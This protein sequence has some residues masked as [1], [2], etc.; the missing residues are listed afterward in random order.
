MTESFAQLF[1]ESLKEIETRPGSIVRGVVVAIDKDVVLVDAGLKSESAIPAEQFKNAQG[2]LEIQVGDEVDVALDAVEDGFGETLLSREKA[3]RHEAWITLEKAYEEA[4]TVVGVINGKVK[5]G[6]TVEL[7]GIRAF[8]PGSLVDVRPVRDTLH[9][10][11]K[12]LEFKVIKLDQKR[13]NVVVSRRAVIESENSAERDQLL[14][15]LQEGM[16]VKGIVKNLTDYG[17]FVDLG[18][19]DGLLHITDMAWKRV[20]HPSEI[21]NVGDE[22]TV[23]VLK[24]DRERTRVSLGLKQLG[25]DPWVAIAKRYPEGTKLTGRVTN[26]TDYGCFVE[27]EEGVEGLVHVSEMDWTNKNIHP[28]K[29]VN[30]G[31]VVEVMVL[32]I[33]EERRRISLGLKQ[34]KNN[35]WQQFAETHNK[36]DR[37]EGK[38][39]SIT[40]FG[41]FIGLDGGIDGLVHLSDISWN[42]AGEEAVREYKK[43]DEIA[44]VVLQVDAERERIS[45]GVKQ[46]AEDPFNNWVALNKKGAIVNGKVTAV[47]AKG[48]TVE[49][50]DGVEGY[51]RASEASRDRVEDATLVLNVGDDVEA[52]FTGVDRKNRAISLSVRAKDEAD[53]K[54]AI[55][56]VNKQ[57]DANFSNNAM[58]EAF[59]AAKGE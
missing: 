8:L 27:I 57:E 6:F 44:A 45:L 20:K 41:I 56:T 14:E 52:K 46:L 35:P 26:L 11:G 49:L 38:I 34:C 2:E 47:D 10:E 7:N 18:G 48:A 4:E 53:E 21:V 59:K 39:K 23:K 28:S 54:D 30:V 31:D 36:G 58:A 29:V 32:D 19:V 13:N 15:N 25:E 37:V 1:E 24:F 12:E 5:G 55:A 43:G 51:L 33:D 9:L 42:V 22:I 16:E 40:D 3:K 50:A 17:A